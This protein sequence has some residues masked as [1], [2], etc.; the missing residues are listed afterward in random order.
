MARL[1]CISE[2]EQHTLHRLHA[3]VTVLHTREVHEVER[4]ALDLLDAHAVHRA[5]G[6]AEQRGVRG[7]AVAICG[8]QV[9]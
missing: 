5:G 7:L 6:D 8:L 3:G 1:E 2:P 9:G 4:L